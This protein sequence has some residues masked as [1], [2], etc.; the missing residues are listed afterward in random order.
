MVFWPLLAESH[1]PHFGNI[2]TSMRFFL[3]QA[4][5]D[6]S[7]QNSIFAY[8]SDQLSISWLW[9]LVNSMMVAVF[10][11]LPMHAMGDA[12]SSPP[13]RIIRVEGGDDFVPY[14]FDDTD[15]RP[16]GYSVELMQAVA[17]QVGLEAD[18]T[19]GPW[20]ETLKKLED[21]KNRCIDRSALFQGAR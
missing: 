9:R 20:H 6:I 15:G 2:M 13:K 1:L 12:T 7:A 16:K 18:I 11:L 10:L 5:L 21:K 17:R 4:S 8:L 3:V 14:Q 19:L